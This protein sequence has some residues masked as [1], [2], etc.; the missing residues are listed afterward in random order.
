MHYMVHFPRLN[1]R[2]GPLV[3]TW[4]LRMEAKH[5]YFKRAA[6]IS[7]CFKIVPYSIARRHKKLLCR[8]LQGKFFSYTDVEC[9]PCEQN[10]INLELLFCSM[11]HSPS[12]ISIYGIN[13]YPN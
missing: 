11:F 2:I 5:L 9:G 4:C 1:T 6:Q 8:L 10:D 7:T 12:W 13:F 3:S